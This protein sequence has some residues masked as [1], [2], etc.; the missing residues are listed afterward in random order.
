[1]GLGWRCGRA[2]FV[3]AF[4]LPDSLIGDQKPEGIWGIRGHW[5]EF[6]LGFDG[7]GK[8]GGRSAFG[9]GDRFDLAHD[10]DGRDEPFV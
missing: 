3:H 5:F 8:H 1:M 6:E 7:V 9:A 2:V 4:V 10:F